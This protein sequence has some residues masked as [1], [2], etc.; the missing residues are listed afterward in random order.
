MPKLLLSRRR[1]FLVFF[2][3]ILK[4]HGHNTCKFHNIPVM[5]IFKIQNKNWIAK[6]HHFLRC[7]SEGLLEN[8][9]LSSG[10]SWNVRIGV[11]HNFLFTKRLNNRGQTMQNVQFTKN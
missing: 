3:K 1:I 10:A 11:L 8:I 6:D 7:E 2:I 9:L 5:R 4:M